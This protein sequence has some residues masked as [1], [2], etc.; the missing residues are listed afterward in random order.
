[1]SRLNNNLKIPK[2]HQ[3]DEISDDDSDE[4]DNRKNFNLQRKKGRSENQPTQNIT[5]PTPDN[6]DDNQEGYV[7]GSIVRIKLNN[8]VT[9]SDVEFR[10]GPRLNVVIGPNGSGKSSI[11]CAIALGLGGSPNLLGRQKQL[12]DFVKRGTMSGFVEIELFNPDGENFIIKRDLKKEGNSGDFKLNGKNITKADLLARIKE[13]NI[14]VENLCQFLPQ[15]KVVGF[16]S[17]SPT[18]LL[19]ETEKAI[20]VDNMYENHQELIKLRSDSSKDNQNIDSQRQQLEEKKDLNQQLE[21]DVERFRE[22]EKILEEIESYKKK[23]AWAIYDNLKRQAENL[24]EEEEREQKNFKEASNELIPLRASIIAQEESLKKTRE[25][26]E[27]LDRKILLLN[28]EVGVCSDGAE[29]VQVQ[30]DSFVKELDGLN[31]RQQKRNRDIEATQTSITQLK[32]EM[33]QLPPEDQDKARIEQINKENRENNTKTNEVQLELQ[34]LHQQYQRVQMDCQKIE[35]EIANLNDGHRQKLEKLKSEGDVFQAYTWIQNNKAKFEKPVYGPVLMEINVVNPEYAS[36]LETSLSWNLLSSFIFQTQK[37]RELFHSSLTDSN[38][39]LRLNSILINNIPP[40][41]RSYDIEDYRQYGAVDYLDNLYEA[42]PIVKAAVNDSI[43]IFKTLVFN[44][45]A[46]G[47]ED[48]LLKSILSFQTP[49]SSYLTSFSRYGDKKSI[50]RV[51]KIKKA[52]WL[53]GINK[54][55]KLE[56]ENSYKEISAKREELKSKGTELKQKEKEIQVASK[57]LLGERAALNLNI[58]KRRKLVNRI[59][60]QINALEDLKNEE[61]IEEEGKKIKSKIYLGYQKKIQLL[62]KAIGFTDELNKSCGAKDHAT[63]SSSRF[64]AK[65][66][67]EKDHL[68][69]ETIRVNQ[70]K[71]RMQQLNKDFKNT[72]RECQLKHQEAQKIAPYTPDLKTQFTKLKGSSLGEIDDEINVLD[73]KASFIVSSNSRVI[74]E[75]EGRKKEI[76]ELEE[77]LSNYEQ[78]AANNNTRLITLKKKWLEPIQE[79]IN[80]INQRFSLFFSEIGCE[81]KVILGN[82][83]KDENDFSKYCINLQVRFRDETS[84]KNLNAQ[85]QSGGERSVSTMLFLISLQNLTKCPFRVVDEINQGMDPKNERMVFEQI[86][87][88]VSKPDLPQYFLITPKLLHNLPYSRET[89]V[90]CVFTGPW[91]ISQQE[92]DEFLYSYLRGAK[93]NNRTTTTIT[94]TTTLNSDSSSEEEEE[95]EEEED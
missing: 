95:E 69:K 82:D 87:K 11:V 12:G 85:L 41:D 6:N 58:E 56:L 43:P 7:K 46:I 62:Q 39:K 63:I 23:K 77:R 36:Y 25:E 79:Y 94:T 20:G 80:Q 71:E 67:S 31:E 37:D 49:E 90:L 47:K 30:I 29:K 27:K 59:N 21:R 1:M 35:K 84:L 50:T 2:K 53:T 14:Q 10:P 34:Q 8:F 45:N 38:R 24:K 19:L 13:L 52:H 60:V 78:T 93:K 5:T 51:I 74:E 32:S 15:D 44:K 76:E 33:D 18:E 55:L 73:A 75:Y 40:V 68:E 89:T 64:E 17:M 54:A 42:N 48:I 66:H 86:V 70:I 61:N 16:A 92:W 3:L 4:G 65:L 28:R 57:E 91:F 83:P 22:R 72:Y 9:Y 81:G 88:T 26:A